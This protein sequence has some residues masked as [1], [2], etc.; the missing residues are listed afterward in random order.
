[1]N[2]FNEF[3]LK[4]LLRFGYRLGF[5][6]NIHPLDDANDKLAILSDI[7]CN[8]PIYKTISQNDNELH[9]FLT[10][11]IDLISYHKQHS[12]APELSTEDGIFQRIYQKYNDS[13][14]YLN[15]LDDD[16]ILFHTTR[17]LIENY[18]QDMYNRLDIQY[19]IL[20]AHKLSESQYLMF[21][22]LIGPDSLKT[23]PVMVGDILP[24]AKANI[25][26]SQNFIH[27]FNPKIYTFTSV[28]RTSRRIID[29]TNHLSNLKISLPCQNEG[30]LKI[31]Y[32]K[33]EFEEAKFVCLKTDELLHSKPHCLTFDEIGII[34]RNKYSFSSIAAEFSKS[35][36]PFS[37]LKSE[38]NITTETDVFKVL[39]LV[40]KIINNPK[41]IY[42]KM[43]L[44]KL[45]D[46]KELTIHAE[47]GNLVEQ[48]LKGTKFDWMINIIGNLSQSNELDFGNI[49]NDLKHK[50]PPQSSAYYNYLF[51][52]DFR[53]WT[54]QWKKFK[55]PSHKI[56]SIHS[57]F[58][59]MRFDGI[60]LPSCVKLLTPDMFSHLTF[61]TVFIID[62]AEG[63]FPD[64]RAVS[65][66]ER[67]ISQER[68]LLQTAVNCSNR[69]C[70]LSY[71]K[72]KKMSWGEIKFL[73]PSR[74]IANYNSYD[75]AS[76]SSQ[77]QEL[78]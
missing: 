24:S 12:I 40:M 55:K 36:I 78:S 2:T 60:F 20:D 5:S 18:L 8:D 57:F 23:G 3:S 11:Y 65:L 73:E 56:W 27:D 39:Y 1:L 22:T 53:E 15:A 38:Q 14:N 43:L 25:N 30:E 68:D 45:L 16:D 63:T 72:S 67:A 7:V 54:E 17:L 69:L 29:F 34:A 9:S 77:P 44:C 28:Y 47:K 32:Y 48:I 51:E 31:D 35:N 21:Q 75:M 58:S 26:M 4:I 10:K 66:G 49:L 19:Y 42:H 74:F 46:R 33:S 13:L 6:H 61:D 62:L 71:A 37:F 52:N 41:E 76:S 70:Y 64:F 59:S 50:F